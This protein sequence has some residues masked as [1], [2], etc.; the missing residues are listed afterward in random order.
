VTPLRYMLPISSRSGTAGGGGGFHLPWPLACWLDYKP[1]PTRLGADSYFSLV[2]KSTL[3]ETCKLRRMGLS[4][5]VYLQCSISDELRASPGP[6]VAY[7]PWFSFIAVPWIRGFET[8]L[9]LLRNL[10]RH[11]A[12]YLGTSQ[13]VFPSILVDSFLRA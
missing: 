13:Q 6:V 11:S 1:Q 8:Y 3:L 5:Y 9:M 10:A 12:H 2:V 4:L 7:L